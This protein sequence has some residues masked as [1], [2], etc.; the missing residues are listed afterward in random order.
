MS[1]AA[2]GCV[3]RYDPPRDFCTAFALDYSDVVMTLQVEPEFGAVAE[4]TAEPHGGVGGN[5]TP[6]VE[7]IGDTPGRHAQIQRESVGDQ[8][9]RLHFSPQQTAGMYDRRHDLPLVKVAE[10]I[11]RA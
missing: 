5:G 6:F 11:T 7:D 2:L 10:N 4:I 1:T 9:P 3:R 8:F